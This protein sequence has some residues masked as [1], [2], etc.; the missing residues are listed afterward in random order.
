MPSQNVGIERLPNTLVGA[1]HDHRYAG[2]VAPV[3]PRRREDLNGTGLSP[4]LDGR[5][6]AHHAAGSF[7]QGKLDRPVQVL[8]NVFELPGHVKDDDLTYVSAGDRP[9]TA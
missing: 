2:P 4:H 3:S 5:Q 1:G 6:V 9:L 7:G 8:D